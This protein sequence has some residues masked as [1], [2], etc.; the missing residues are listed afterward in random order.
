MMKEARSRANLA[1]EQFSRARLPS[2]PCQW[3]RI[4]TKWL[5]Y[6]AKYR[7]ASRTTLIQHRLGRLRRHYVLINTI[8]ERQ[9]G[10]N[11]CAN[12]KGVLLV[13]DPQVRITK[14]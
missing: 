13:I 10:R 3:Q 14:A 4:M 11:M 7:E 12:P 6:L 5:G 1:E 8:L 9:K 2:I